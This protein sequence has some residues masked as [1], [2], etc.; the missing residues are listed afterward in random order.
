MSPCWTSVKVSLP[1][2]PPRSS[3]NL[4]ASSREGGMTALIIFIWIAGV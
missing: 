2:M 1:Q 4:M 3:S